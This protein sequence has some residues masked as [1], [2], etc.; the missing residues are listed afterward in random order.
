MAANS[1]D[2]KAPKPSRYIVG[3]DLG[4]TNCAVGYVAQEDLNRRPLPI[5]SFQVPQLTRP[6]AVESCPLLPSFLYLPAEH[7]MPKGSTALPW[8]AKRSVIIG[9]LA[10]EMG[11]RVP[12]RLVASAKSWLCSP[13]VDRTAAILPWGAPQDVQRVSPVA[14]S[15]AYLSHIREAWDHEIAKK[16]ESQKLAAQDVVI[17]VPASF[18]EAARE[19]TVAAARAAGFARFILIEEP[20]AAF[21]AW[22]AVHSRAL[23]EELNGIGRVLVCDVGGGTTD[24]SLIDVQ[25]TGDPSRPIV[26]RRTAVGDHLMLGGDNMDLALA[27]H[28]EKKIKSPI[29]AH[30]FKALAAAARGAKERLLA[31]GAPEKI[32]LSIMG[33]GTQVIGGSVRTE[34]LKAEAE[35]ILLDGFFPETKLHEDP[36]TAGRSGIREWGL[37]YVHDA[38]VTRHMSQF[39]RQHTGN[40]LESGSLESGVVAARKHKTP[41]SVTPDSRLS[42]DAVL[43][44]GGAMKPAAFRLRIL[45]V[46]GQWFGTKPPVE[47]MGT[48]L[49]HAVAVGAAAY[50]CARRGAGMRI[51]GGMG[52]AYYIGIET[53]T[54]PERPTGKAA[55][56]LVPQGAEEG[57]T[58]ELPQTFTLRLATPVIFPLFSSSLRPS[59]K[60]GSL[61]DEESKE[62][63]ALP[64]LETTLQTGR[65]A[66]KRDVAV[67]LKASLTEIGTLALALHAL[68]DQRSWEVHLNVRGRVAQSSGIA[69]EDAAGTEARP[70]GVDPRAETTALA[71]LDRT[72]N[73]HS[74][75]PLPP[76]LLTK[77]LEVALSMSKDSWPGALAR[78]MADVLLEHADGRSRSAEHESRWLNLTGFLLRPGFGDVGDGERLRKLYNATRSGPAFVSD[79]NVRIE[80]WVLWRRTAAGLKADHERELFNRLQPF[81]TGERDVTKR[82]GWPRPTKGELPEMWRAAGSLELLDTPQK[83]LLGQRIVDLLDK[84]EN[85]PV[86]LWSL[87]RIGAR[88]PV[89]AP[90]N[91]AVPPDLAEAW[92]PAVF[93]LDWRKQPMAIFAAVN[94]ARKTGDRARDLSDILRRKTAERLKQA[95]ASEHE[96]AAVTTVVGL[97]VADRRQIFGE[98]PPP[99]LKL[100]GETGGR[101]DG[102]T[103]GEW[104]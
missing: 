36:A 29:D 76:G 60:L 81:L 75:Q 101:G 15:A 30:Q 38:A 34:L 96:L 23:E 80:W 31:S 103:G 2:T 95:H 104:Q 97:E 102:E 59:D 93:A 72:F 44:N 20:Q 58:L 52:R 9:E 53:E 79:P 83:K 41:D 33:R 94:L 7:E 89:H 67:R 87:A 68:G 28:L 48:S 65:H 77:Q 55:V 14:A 91:H 54:A 3:I 70:T 86:L 6:G 56:C 39:L 42:L 82:G 100:D 49:D 50:G 19:L 62:L 90:A 22:M 74:R 35:T 46:L 71:L 24:F 11:A 1:S 12:G 51:G 64:P 85:L 40:S 5:H 43:F 4:T 25:R 69:G 92:L 10:R 45:N 18:D 13:S 61:I 32:S 66:V 27:R 16:D 88:E 84:D 8:D 78:R 21:Y 63:A 26:L 99:A 47:L 37:P 73:A 98:S 17:T 57:Q